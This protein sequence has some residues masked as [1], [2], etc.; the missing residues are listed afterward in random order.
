M[1]GGLK[2]PLLS[3]AAKIAGGA[4]LA[5]IIGLALALF[6]SQRQLDK[7][8]AERD[9]WQKDHAELAK[10]ITDAAYPLTGVRNVTLD[11]DAAVLQVEALGFAYTDTL[12]A[13][14]FKN[15]ESEKRAAE[16]ETAKAKADAAAA[17]NDAKFAGTQQR[18]EVVK[19]AAAA[20]PSNGETCVVPAAIIEQ[21]GDL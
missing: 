17:R 12:A 21:L 19:A 1:I 16:Y 9:G 11:H 6:F 20:A 18:V 13:L 3:T 15:A 4:A 2:L 14:A 10:A 8:S 5:V 7:V